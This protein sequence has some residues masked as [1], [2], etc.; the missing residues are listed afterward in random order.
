M[1]NL[2]GCCYYCIELLKD[3]DGMIIG[4]LASAPYDS[5]EAY[6]YKCAKLLLSTSTYDF[7]FES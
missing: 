1:F 6:G 2:R 5:C 7:Y 4:P 3:L